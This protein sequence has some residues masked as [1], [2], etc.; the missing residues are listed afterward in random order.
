MGRFE[1]H[2][3]FSN[4]IVTSCPAW[5]VFEWRVYECP[6]EEEISSSEGQDEGNTYLN[7][8]KQDKLPHQS[9]LCPSYELQ[10]VSGQLALSFSL[11]QC[12]V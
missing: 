3:K 9:C 11:F 7:S 10:K 12:G 2:T 6:G 5:K 8:M 4:I 1:N